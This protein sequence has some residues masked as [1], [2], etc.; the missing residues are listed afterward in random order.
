MLVAITQNLEPIHTTATEAAA[1]PAPELAH[2]AIDQATIPP[3]HRVTA[4]PGWLDALAR[5]TI[6]IPLLLA[7]G[8][9]LFIVNLGGYPLY[10]KG[11]PRE[12]VIVLNMVQGG[13]LILPMRAGVELPS[14]PPLMHWLAAALSVLAGRVNEWTVRLPSASLAV[15]GIL[16][17]Y[18]YV[19]RLFD[20]RSALLSA[21]ML[22]ST[23]QYLQA[24]SGARVDITLTFFMEIAFFEFLM[25]AEGLT[26]RRLPLYFAMAAAVLAKG[27]V[28]VVLPAAVAAIWIA[29]ERRFDLIHRLKLVQGAIILFVF[30]GGW[31]L[32]AIRVG[33]ASFFRKQILME[34]VFT[35]LHSRKLSG[36]HAHPFYY[37][38]LS[39]LAGFFPWSIFIPGIAIVF[40]RKP[41]LSNPRIRYL[42]VWIATVLVFYSVAHS[43]RG[44]YLLAL[45]PALAAAIA[46]FLVDAI[47]RSQLR[48]RWVTPVSLAAGGFFL[49]AA[50][51]A[52]F[53]VA[54]L[55]L[56]PSTLGNWLARFGVRAT[57]LLPALAHRMHTLP[58]LLIIAAI[59]AL[60]V[61][62]L[63]SQPRIQN[64]VLAIAAGVACMTLA[65]NLFV[66][67]AIADALSLKQF[68]HDAMAIIDGHSVAYQGT[69]NYDFAFYSGKTIPIV[70]NA[71]TATA[72]YLLM[73]ADNYHLLT[74]SARNN[75]PIALKSGPTDLDGSG[76]M[77]LLKRAA[78]APSGSV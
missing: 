64:T 26:E 34:N 60:G 46:L 61:Y 63:R 37:V 40:G 5:P 70:M 16:V 41:Y 4:D 77:L 30:A 38:E 52:L 29:I 25:V 44:V 57:T 48:P 75:F 31:Y 9:I 24:G 28:G 13:G 72:D 36:G 35:F 14:K 32:A 39:L 71:D 10:T 1:D 55:D 3:D 8:L 23:L 15:L 43:K 51:A 19:R 27:P 6:A 59:A 49:I 21:L 12:A 2:A 69:L 62:L 45:Y 33:G 42:I 11:E 65:A 50:T 54:I 22:G 78:P 56:S 58:A 67:A 20:D 68:T 66:A 76:G 47:D 18:L 17:C 74:A 73:W 53:G 7:F